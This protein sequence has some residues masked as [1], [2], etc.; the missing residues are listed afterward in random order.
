M[1]RSQGRHDN[2]KEG[3]EPSTDFNL[4]EENHFFKGVS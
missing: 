1:M 2:I 4:P 3:L